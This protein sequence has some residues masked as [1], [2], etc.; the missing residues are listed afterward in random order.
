M[1]PIEIE[2]FEATYS[3]KI[4]N[5]RRHIIPSN[6]D[7]TISFIH[8]NFCVKSFKQDHTSPSL[9]TVNLDHFYRIY[10][11][12]LKSVFSW[13]PR[14]IRRLKIEDQL[15]PLFKIS[16]LPDRRSVVCL[17]E[18]TL[19]VALY[20]RTGKTTAFR[21]IAIDGPPETPQ[22]ITTISY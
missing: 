1:V 20:S 14:D 13:K 19:P 4:I 12:G 21:R 17:I 15:S 9:W 18:V 22:T 7:H 5:N 16:R 10:L 11:K 3:P 8:W 6:F 2:L